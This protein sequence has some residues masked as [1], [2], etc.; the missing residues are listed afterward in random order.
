[1][2]GTLMIV[3]LLP[4][5]ATRM[6]ANGLTYT[7]LMSAFSAAML[8]SSPLWGRFSDRYGRRPT[9]LVALA[10]SAVSYVVF[11]AANSLTVLFISRVIQ[12]AGGGTVGVLQAY[13][14]D[15]TEP[16]NRV[17]ALGW[18]SAATNVGVVVGPALSTAALWIG[19][20][21]LGIGTHDFVLGNRAP[22]VFAALLC[23]VNMYFAWRYLRESHVGAHA[24]GRDKKVSTPRAAIW[25]V[26]RHSDDPAPR[27]IWIYAVAIGAYYSTMQILALFLAK[28]F[29]VTAANIGWVFTYAGLV[30]VI[31]RILVL[32]PALDRFG[33]ARLWRIGTIILA[34]GFV[35]VPLSPSL[36]AFYVALTL[37]PVGASLTFPC[38]TGLLSRVISVDDRGVYMG[39]QQAF[40]GVARVVFPP[41]VGWAWDAF[42]YQV[43]F[44]GAGVVVA[45]TLALGLDMHTYLGPDV[46]VDPA[47]LMTS[48]PE[49]AGLTTG[50]AAL[51][52]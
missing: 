3:P 43:P 10:A 46:A 8:L 12:G 47:A 5:Y 38:V 15:A 33:E 40:G 34:L 41:A 25:R 30:N 16:K 49:S 1:M 4:F 36:P 28:R 19:R 2:M 24:L 13:V 17:K 11:A 39:V 14:A 45:G 32:G 31:A 26:I 20:H 51:R 9:L 29:G 37:F 48:P 42:P 18:L 6:G 35:I 44:W 50:P 27:L 7:L 22:G 52:K 21:R 23:M